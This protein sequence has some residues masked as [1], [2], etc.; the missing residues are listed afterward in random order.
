MKKELL[1]VELTTNYNHDGQAW[2]GYG[3]FNRTRKTVYFNGR[4]L[5]KGRSSVGNYVDIISGEECWVSGVKKNGE[6]R[7]WAGHGKIHI[8]KTAIK[9]YLKQINE[10]KLPSNKFVE[11]EF[12]NTPNIELA[13]KIENQKL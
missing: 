10:E 2:I 11:V 1:Y 4:I 5:G 8:D 13:S 9:D 6:D 3:Q 7:H 12:N